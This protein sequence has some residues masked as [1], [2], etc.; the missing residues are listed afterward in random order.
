MVICG[1]N[2]SKEL[3]MVADVFSMIMSINDCVFMLER[4]CAQAETADVSKKAEK[5]FRDVTIN[6]EKNTDKE[7]IHCKF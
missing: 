5:A 6:K 2:R 4:V 1:R 7:T 3:G